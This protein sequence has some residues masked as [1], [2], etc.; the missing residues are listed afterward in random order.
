MDVHFQA[1]VTHRGPTDSTREEGRR[2]SELGTDHVYP[3]T[4]YS[5]LR[6]SVVLVDIRRIVASAARHN[7]INLLARSLAH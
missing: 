1:L 3:P 2:G 4:I 5:P 6:I 7:L